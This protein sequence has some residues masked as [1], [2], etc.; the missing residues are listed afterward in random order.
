MQYP[1][2]VQINYRKVRSEHLLLLLLACATAGLGVYGSTLGLGSHDDLRAIVE[3]SISAILQGSYQPSRSL[4]Y[5]LY[6]AIA[7][8][9][10]WMTGSLRTINLYSL[11]LAIASLFIFAGLLDKTLGKKRRS[12]VLIGFAFNPL[13]LVNS[14]TVTEWVQ[15]V[16][17]LLLLLV[18]AKFCLSYRRNADLIAYGLCS[19]L[20]VLTRPDSVFVCGALLIAMLWTIGA[21]TRY[22]AKLVVTSLIAGIVTA[23]I[24]LIINHGLDFFGGYALGHDTPLR[25]LVMTVGS[26]IN[27]FG[28]AGTAVIALLTLEVARRAFFQERSEVT[29]WGRV[30]LV[31]E[32][33][34]IFRFFMLPEKLEFLLP[35]VIIG[36]LAAAH[37]RLASFWVFLLSISLVITSAVSVSLFK[38]TGATDKLAFDIGL[39]RG[40]LAQE[41]ELTRYNHLVTTQRFLEDVA[42]IVHE[43]QSEPKLILRSINFMK[44]LISN[45]N[46]LIIGK[47]ELYRLDNPRFTTPEYRRGSYRRIYI[48]DKSI[49]GLK[50]G[51]RVLQRPLNLPVIDPMTGRLALHCWR[52][53]SGGAL[54]SI[55]V[56]ME[57]AEFSWGSFPSLTALEYVKSEGVNLVRLPIAWEMMQPTLNG[58]L[59]ATYLA[60][61]EQF[62]SNANS[63]GIKVI[64]DLHNAGTYNLNWAADVAAGENIGPGTNASVLGSAAV[65]I[66]AFADFWQQLATALNGNPAVAGYDIMNEPN[67]L[68]SPSTWPT[69]AQAAVDAIRSV[70]MNTPIIVEGDQ[71]AGASSWLANNANLN[72][73]DPANDIIYEAH[74]YF[75]NGSGTYTETYAQS[76]DTANTGV[77][78]IAPF[79]QWLQQNGYKGYL[80]EFGIPSDNATTAQWLPLLE[81]VL[82]TLQADGLPATVW[83]FELP[84]ASDPS[85]WVS[86]IESSSSGNLNIAPIN[87]QINP[88]MALIFEHSAP[89]ITS[90]SPNSGIVGDDSTN[91]N[92]LT[93]TGVGAGNATVN[94]YDGTTLLGTT[95]ATVNGAWSFTTAAL[96]NGAHSFTA[97]DVDLSGDVSEASA[98]LVVTVDA[99]V[100]WP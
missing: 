58:A 33:I 13:I 2:L 1:H 51:W 71:W 22:A 57:G 83:N 62:L 46:D 47:D 74:Q 54:A 32:P 97:T 100:R 30:F 72:I 10:Y 65:P 6:E 53:L 15:M 94:V 79:L 56:N 95:T 48:C 85:W 73:V 91:A 41:W 92:V 52:E 25:R 99:M 35:L 64:V 19:G 78:E 60:G 34:L 68:P 20:L 5:P 50:P 76:G 66:S 9:L 63:L 38:R 23:S 3:R 80:G 21:F 26:V 4:G 37:E 43:Q 44:G 89:V 70:D 75:D 18:S 36:L 61:L 27:L 84:N 40:A 16:F 55:G 17:F 87:G 29:W 49:M 7:A 59:S 88:V 96:S 69:A 77:Q 12:L 82:N 8:L 11:V 93:L 39:N 98:A 14:S 24:F 45:Q 67:S 86:T 28:P 31:A 90:F 81:N 42:D